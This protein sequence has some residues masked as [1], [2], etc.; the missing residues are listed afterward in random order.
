MHAIIGID[1]G[2]STT[3]IAGFQDEEMLEPIL[4]KAST[5]LASLFGA[6]GQFMIENNLNLDDVKEIRLTGVGANS[7]K[8][9]IYGIPTFKVDEFVANGVG[10]RFFSKNKNAVVVS[11]GTGTS[12]VLVDEKGLSY[13]GGI[14]IG[15]GTIIGLSKLLLHTEDVEVI[16]EL[17]KKGHVDQIDLRIKDISPEPLQ[18]LDLDITACNFGKVAELATREDIAA[19]IVHMVLES[20]FHTGTLIAQDKGVDE[21]ILIGSLAN[22]D[23]CEFISSR[24]ANMAGENVHFVVPDKG[25]FGTAIGA[26]RAIKED[27]RVIS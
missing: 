26:A 17:S 15:G 14:A 27:C 9:D 3:K 12:Y 25:G 2:G 4:V 18:G 10:G 5:P 16:Q 22:F 6:F 13:L 20:I 21:F 8:Q 24:C 7:V 23:E 1:I 11:M 19:G